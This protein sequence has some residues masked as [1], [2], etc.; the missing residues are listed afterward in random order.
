[1]E[2]YH[3]ISY[4]YINKNARFTYVV[5][6]WKLSLYKSV[7]LVKFIS[8]LIKRKIIKAILSKY[9]ELIYIYWLDNLFSVDNI[10][11]WNSIV[12][13]SDDTNETVN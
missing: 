8:I 3:E 6:T 10:V 7:T 1:M 4:T 12:A 2:T 11:L 5:G 9:V 13:A